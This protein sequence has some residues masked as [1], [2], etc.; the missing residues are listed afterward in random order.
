MVSNQFLKG[1][2]LANQE[3]KLHMPC[4]DNAINV[5]DYQCPMIVRRKWVIFQDELVELE[6]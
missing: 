1:I 5:I 6:N 2:Y 4:S 3:S